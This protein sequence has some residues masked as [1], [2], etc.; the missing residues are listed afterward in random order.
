MQIDL[1][2][3]LLFGAFTVLTLG[4]GLAVVLDRN[5]FHAALW[6]LV[7]LF[8]VAGFF[9]MLGAPFFAAVQVLVYIGA[10]VIL[11][12]IAV[13]LTRRVMGVR[14]ASNN[15]WAL[16]LAASAVAFVVIALAIIG[17]TGGDLTTA[18]TAADSAA[19]LVREPI[20]AE[21]PLDSI[22]D[23]GKSLVDPNQYVVPFVLASMLLTGAMIGS[24]V[25][26]REE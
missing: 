19:L 7:S 1:I 11:I 14:E 4:G 10:I 13:M 2:Q 5:I 16:G 6:L 12:I 9:V 3:W 22:A 24:I 17:A 20:T 25:I 8:G 18:A 15:Q 21:V 26:A 23:F